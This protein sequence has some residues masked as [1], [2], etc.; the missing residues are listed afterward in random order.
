MAVSAGGVSAV[1]WGPF[2]DGGRSAPPAPPT[3]GTPKDLL[4][5]FPLNRQPVEGWQVTAAG[6]G[7]PP[8]VQLGKLFAS[9]GNKAYFITAQG[10]DRKCLD[11]V[12]WLYGIDTSSGTRLFPPLSLPGF[13]SSGDNCYGNGPSVAVCT[14]RAPDETIEQDFPPPTAWV[15]DLDH[16]TVSFSGAN[17]LN[18]KRGGGT[19]L[20]AVGNDLG[21][22]YLLAATPGKGVYGVGKRAELTWFVPG[23]GQVAT[24]V[25]RGSDI[26]PL[27]LAVQAPTAPGDER[28]SRVF[29]VIDGTDLTPGVPAGTRLE[30]AEVYHGGFVYQFDSGA[31]TGTL[32]YDT[33][34]R[35]VARQDSERSFPRSNPAMPTLLVGSTFQFY[36]AAGKLLIDVPARGLAE[37]FRTIGTKVYVRKAATHGSDETWQSWDLLTGAPGPAC[38]MQLGVSYVGSDGNVVVALRGGAD[39]AFAAVDVATCQTLW[40][41]TGKVLI[42]KIGSGLVEIDYDHQTIMSLRAPN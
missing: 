26:P 39:E 10:C 13:Y 3:I 34:G 33:A 19:Q 8:G 18:P 4:V 5:S 35:Q 2:R 23:S 42:S 12:G 6:I 27:T 41:I 24:P 11:P 37:E 15:I 31:V 30:E 9:N 25:T 1:L 40:E 7:L 16:G 28:G 14:T 29:S 21:Q 20:S 17:T 38:A 32:M 22:T 36:T